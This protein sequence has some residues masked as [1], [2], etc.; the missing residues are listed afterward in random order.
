M[1]LVELVKFPEL[2][3]NDYELFFV[4]FEVFK[5]IDTLEDIV[6]VLLFV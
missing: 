3:F 1:L 2:V 6:V 4:V 5:E